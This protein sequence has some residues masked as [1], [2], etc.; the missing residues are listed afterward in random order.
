ML[1]NST[2]AIPKSYITSLPTSDKII[3]TNIMLEI[4]HILIF[5]ILKYIIKIYHSF[6]PT[7]SHT[8]HVIKKIKTNDKLNNVLL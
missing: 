1:P 3:T 4:N 5:H 6:T 8:T 2:N 7:N